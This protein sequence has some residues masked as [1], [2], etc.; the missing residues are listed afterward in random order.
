MSGPT[1]APSPERPLATVGVLMV[2]PSGRLLLIRTHK[3]RDRWGVP[4]GKIDYGE[5]ILDAVRREAR[6]ETGLEL[7][8]VRW[9]PVQEAVESPEFHRAAHFV[10]LNFFAR[11][12]SETVELNDE[13]QAFA[14][15]TPEEALAMDLNTPTRVLVNAYLDAAPDAPEVAAHG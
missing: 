12:G 3:W 7:A 1:H 8:D 4:G 13:A 2:G 11:T 15:V 5:G 10:L 6:E 9:G 14:W